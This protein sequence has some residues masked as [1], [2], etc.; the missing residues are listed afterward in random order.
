MK[1]LRPLIKGIVQ[2]AFWLLVWQILAVFVSKPL[3]LPSPWHVLLRLFELMRQGAFWGATLTSLVRI[4][5]GM[6]LAV[7][8]GCLLAVLTSASKIL[9][10]LISP[11]LA[12]VRSTPVVSFIMLALLWLG[13]DV[14]PAFTAFLMVVPVVWA[15]IYEGI[16]STDT[17]LL[18][19]AKVFGFSRPRAIRRVYAPSVLPFFLSAIRSAIGFAWK[20][21]ITA[22]VL[23]VPKSSIG[24]MVYES[25]LNLETADLF[26]WTLVVILCSVIIE[27]LAVSSISRLSGKYEARSVTT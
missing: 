7:C 11:L 6:I 20:A 18:Q 3:L 26:A 14:L 25:K 2:L 24:R 10:M 4:L 27:K 1:K 23:T 19:M 17:D 15:N 12:V 21:G 5:L 8:L 22:E 16:K 9:Y 13:R